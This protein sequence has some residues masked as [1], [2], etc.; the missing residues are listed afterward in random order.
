MGQAE[1]RVA[2]GDDFVLRLHL[3]AQFVQGFRVGL[4]SQ[5]LADQSGSE[6]KQPRD[7]GGNRL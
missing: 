4:N 2:D 7:G 1:H 5:L 6:N 3:L